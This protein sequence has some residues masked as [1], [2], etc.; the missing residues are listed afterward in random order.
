MKFS[1]V[2]PA[3]NE[4][5]VIGACFDSIDRAAEVFACSREI[6][7]VLNR[8][9]DDTE[10]IAR[11][12]GAKVARDDSKNLSR[13]RNTGARRAAGNVLIMIDADS[14]MS[15]NM[16]KEIDRALC[17]GKYIGGGVPIHPERMSP[18]ILLTGLFSMYLSWYLVCRQACSGATGRILNQ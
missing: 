1:I 13:I 18:G 16:L 3:H 6:I 10:M 2:I 14:T 7:V 4:E 8:C 17:S 12:R 15:H 9:T 11:S 5:G